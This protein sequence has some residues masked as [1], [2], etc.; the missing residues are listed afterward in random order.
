MKLSKP[1]IA[2]HKYKKMKLAS[3]NFS[4]LNLNSVDRCLSQNATGYY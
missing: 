1:G 3:L 2:T 4:Q